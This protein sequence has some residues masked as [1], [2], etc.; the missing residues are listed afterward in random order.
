MRVVAEES[1]RGGWFAHSFAPPTLVGVF[2]AKLTCK[3]QHQADAELICGDEASQLHGDV[4]HAGD[5][6]NPLKLSSDFAPF[7]PRCDLLLDATSNSPSHGPE[8]SWKTRWAVGDWSK[9]L[10]VFGDRRWVVEPL[11][12]RVGSPTPI[13]EMPL[14]YRYAFGGPKSKN[15]PHGRG[16]GW[17]AEQL[18]NI[19]HAAQSV[20]SPDNDLPP[21]GVGPIGVDWPVR[22]KYV[23][24][25]DQLWQ[26]TRWP[27]FPADFN[28]AYFNAAPVDQQL[29]RELIGDEELFFENLHPQIADYRTRLPGVRVRCFVSNSQQDPDQLTMADFREVPLLCDTLQIDMH[30]QTATLIFR[31]STPIQSLKMDEL[32]TVFMLTEEIAHSPLSDSDCLARFQALLHR[33]DGEPVDPAEL[34]AEEAEQQAFDAKMEQLEVEHATAM[35]E[36]EQHEAQA[37]QRALAAGIDASKL[38][39]PGP[40]SLAELRAQ[41]TELAG[42]LRVSRPEQARELDERVVEIK[43]LEK[44]EAEMQADSEEKL[45]REDVVRMAAAGESFHG[46]SLA[47]LELYDLQLSGLDFSEVDFSECMLDGS[48]LSGANLTG[49]NF[50]EADLTQANLSEA[51]LDHAD[52][53]ESV[54]EGCDF[55]NAS[56][57]NANLSELDLTGLSFRGVRGRGA[58]FSQSKLV[59]ADFTGAQLPQADLSAADVS[60][61][62][63]ERAQLAAASFEGVVAHGASLRGADLTGLHASEQAD[64]SGSDFRDCSADGS[65]W[66]AAILQRCNFSQS[67]LRQAIFTGG[68]LTQSRFDR[69]DLSDSVFDDADLS[70]AS[71]DQCNLIRASLDRANLTAASLRQANI[72]Q[73]GF[74]EAQLTD[75]D[76]RGTS[77]IGT[78]LTD[79]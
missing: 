48:N 54:L 79:E 66:D 77:L 33:D 8:P 67:S 52:F 74:W 12:T 53:S 78:V 29:D 7:K 37:R 6:A 28:Y 65:I 70:G 11:G 16:F 76:R 57:E 49:A 9:T 50:S 32:Q 20:T 24:S 42:V 71:L 39:Q 19:E 75:L 15:N 73:A 55:T 26:R 46:R 18:P 40:T 72:Y 56:L 10:R 2:L 23:G 30:T 41:M 5:P 43:E 64:F 31:G 27:W 69:C 62:T 36:A 38:D 14:D 63:F 58:D 47:D 61:A 22:Q 60:D 51:R 44:V 1:I 3:L 45:T 59:G 17:Q 35:K 34:A 4:H 13:T 25:Y 21:A 68:H